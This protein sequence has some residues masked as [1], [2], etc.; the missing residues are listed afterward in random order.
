MTQRSWPTGAWGL[1][2]RAIVWTLTFVGDLGMALLLRFAF[3]NEEMFGLSVWGSKEDLQTIR[4][5]LEVVH[6]YRPASLQRLASARAIMICATRS[7]VDLR[8]KRAYVDISIEGQIAYDIV[9]VSRAMQLFPAAEEDGRNLRRIAQ[10]IEDDVLILLSRWLANDR[11][12]LWGDSPEDA[13]A[14]QR[15]ELHN[16]IPAIW[17]LSVGRP[18]KLR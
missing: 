16:R 2:R 4:A 7:A 10:A 15:A 5:G 3:K 14:R 9:A 8:R 13:I 11:E 6:R 17:D 1:I 18:G 12:L